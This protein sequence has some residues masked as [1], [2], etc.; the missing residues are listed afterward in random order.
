M[1]KRKY[2]K[3]RRAEQQDE[4]RARIVEATVKLHEELGPANTTIKAVAEEAGVQRLTVYRHF[5]DEVS[6]FKACSTSYL[7]QHPPP[8]MTDWAQ[9]DNASERSY[10]ALLA[11]YRYY[12]QTEKMWA[13]VY[14]DLDKVEA[15]KGPVAQF[16]AYIDAVSDDLLNAWG[17]THAARKQLRVTLRH[18]IRF[19]TWQ[20]L[21]TA[22]LN[23]EK[24][25]E[26]VKA[27]LFGFV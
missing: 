11:F 16:E 21:K 4:T 19:S 23:D 8:N 18:A 1:K 25:A 3:T 9:I 15:L 13:V 6:L 26:L 10:T 2:T 24:M 27:W 14:R 5:P 12:R 7:E 22:K 17:K 20:S